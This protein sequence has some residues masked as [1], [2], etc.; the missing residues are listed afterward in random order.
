MNYTLYLCFCY[1]NIYMNEYK[2]LQAIYEGQGG[3]S[4]DTAPNDSFTA[5][6]SKH[7]FRY[8]LPFNAGGSENVFASRSNDPLTR[9]IVPGESEEE[10]IDGEISKLAIVG[11]IKELQNVAAKDGRWDCV[12]TL[13][14]LIKFIKK[15]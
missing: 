2:Q 10:Q 12:H 8:G 13:G 9:V 6:S 5:A 14:T 1:I 4:R 15:S 3:L 7:S 11:K